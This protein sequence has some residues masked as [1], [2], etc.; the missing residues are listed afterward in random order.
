MFQF[1]KISIV[2]FYRKLFFFIDRPG[3]IEAYCKRISQK[4]ENATTDLENHELYTFSQLFQRLFLSPKEKCLSMNYEE[5]LVELKKTT[6]SIAFGFRPWYYQTCSEFGWYQT[7]DLEKQPFGT[8]SP[9]E[10]YLKLCR[11][12]FGEDV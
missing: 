9:V 10:F 8:N 5:D 11:D 3:L 4:N 2:N 1:F 12:I 7:T 6:G